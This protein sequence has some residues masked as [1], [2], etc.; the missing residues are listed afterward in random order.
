VD[1]KRASRPFDCC[2]L[3]LMEILVLM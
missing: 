1:S 2:K 3:E